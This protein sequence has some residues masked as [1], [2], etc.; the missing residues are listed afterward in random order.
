MTKLPTFYPIST[1]L[2]L[3]LSCCFAI[4][5][6]AETTP[7]FSKTGFS[8]YVARHMRMVWPWRD[9]ARFD[10]FAIV[11]DMSEKVMHSTDYGEEIATAMTI[12]FE[13][14]PLLV[15]SDE[16]GDGRA[17]FYAYHD[18]KREEVTYEF[19]AFFTDP[20]KDFPYWIVFNGGP[21]FETSPSGE[22][23]FYWMNYQFV[24]RNGDGRCDVYVTN[25]VSYKGDGSTRANDTLWL[26]D[27]DYD[28]RLDRA[29]HIID[30]VAHPVKTVDG[31]LDTRRPFEDPG[32]P[33]KIGDETPFLFGSMIAA[34]IRKA[35]SKGQ[36]Q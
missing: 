10:A 26:Y 17:D 32:Q 27:D 30:G 19:G 22:F 33:L 13:G 16:D 29:E 11:T 3:C 7:G 8:M 9:E 24:D 1:G 5:A 23:T 25:N 18:E 2:A 14:F 4:P 6:T 20:G 35:L 12:G 34:D 15:L 21:S 31:R 28:G 36:D